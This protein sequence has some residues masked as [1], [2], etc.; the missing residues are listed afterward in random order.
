MLERGCIVIGLDIN[1]SNTIANIDYRKVDILDYKDIENLIRKLFDQYERIDGVISFAAQDYKIGKMSEN[2]FKDEERLAGVSHNDYILSVNSAVNLYNSLSSIKGQHNISLVLVGSDLSILAPYQKLYRST[3]HPSCSKPIAYSAVKHGMVGVMK[4][5][6]TYNEGDNIRCNL[7]CPS[8]V[9][10][11]SM[12]EQFEK[13]LSA[14]NPMGR[15]CSLDELC[16]PAYFLLSS[17]SQFV[18]GQTL[19][20]D[21][22]RSIW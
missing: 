14:L 12:G 21:G 1:L 20:V 7:L 4:Y 9:N 10:D 8:G 17:M 19:V 2:S 16:G 13:A 6:A 22:G 15:L 5:L 18:N 3:I 11:G